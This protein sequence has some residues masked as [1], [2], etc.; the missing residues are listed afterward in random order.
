MILQ[1][2]NFQKT[3]ES[4]T[5]LN[6]KK[7]FIGINVFGNEKHPIYVSKKCWEKKH[8]DLLL[9]GE[10]GKGHYVLIKD[11]NTFMYDHKLHH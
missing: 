7:N 4:F 10:E 1:T 2:Q 9:I 5:K 8:V 6:E 11:C 3:L